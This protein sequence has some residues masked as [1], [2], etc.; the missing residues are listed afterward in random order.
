[1]QES[2]NGGSRVVFGLDAN[3]YLGSMKDVMFPNFKK[4]GFVYERVIPTSDCLVKLMLPSLAFVKFKS[5]KVNLFEVQNCTQ[6]T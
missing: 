4:Y 3:F 6:L 5:Q 1:M 2:Y